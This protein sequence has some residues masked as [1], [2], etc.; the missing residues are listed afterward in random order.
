MSEVLK[1]HHNVLRFKMKSTSV[2]CLT[3]TGKGNVIVRG[4]AP[5]IKIEIANVRGTEKEKEVNEAMTENGQGIE[6]EKEI[7]IGI[8]TERGI[9]IGIE[10]M[11]MKSEAEIVIVTGIVVTE[12]E[13]ATERGIRIIVLP[14]G[15]IVKMKNQSTAVHATKER[16]LKGIKKKKGVE[17]GEVVGVEVRVVEWE[18]AVEGLGM[19]QR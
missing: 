3:G 13:I 18:E 15:S 17:E 10:I 11:N 19:L 5:V 4:N 2:E 16:D 12:I 7:G 14:D 1:D 8:G 6:I 9:G